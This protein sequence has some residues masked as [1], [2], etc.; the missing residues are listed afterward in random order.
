MHLHSMQV[1]GLDYAHP[2]FPQGNF[3][4][5]TLMADVQPSMACYKAEIFGPVTED[6][7]V[8][9]RSVVPLVCGR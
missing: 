9:T 5:P 2:T 1:D 3:L 6:R 7:A 4:G 8:Q